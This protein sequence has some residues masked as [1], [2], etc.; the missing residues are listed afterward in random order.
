M[1][2]ERYRI[3][4]P[5][6]SLGDLVGELTTEFSALVSSHIALAKAEIRQDAKDAGK[7]GGMLGGAGAAAL[8]ASLMLSA[9]AAWGLAEVMEPGWAFLIVGVVWLVVAA[10]LALSGKRELDD[11]NPGPRKTMEELEED[12][13]WLKTQRR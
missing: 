10:V 2:D 3:E 9:A 8:I 1:T 7:A 11:M 12:K 6:K 5:D 13:Q 4:Q